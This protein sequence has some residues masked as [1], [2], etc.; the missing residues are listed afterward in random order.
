LK[1]EVTPTSETTYHDPEPGTAGFY[2]IAGTLVI[3]R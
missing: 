3:L 1:A 2:T